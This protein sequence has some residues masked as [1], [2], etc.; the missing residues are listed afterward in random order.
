[1][2]GATVVLVHGAGAGA[3]A[4]DLVTAELDELGIAHREVDLPSCG[5]KPP[6]DAGVAGD[7]AVVRDL[8][9]ALTGPVV[10]VGNSYGGV[11]I[12]A[13]A[14]DHPAVARLVYI[15]AH[16]PKA[17]I[18]L[19]NQLEGTEESSA[20]LVLTEDGRAGFDPDQVATLAFQ[21]ADPETAKRVI[22][23]LQ[24]VLMSD[25]MD[26][27]L[28]AVAWEGIPSTYIVCTEDHLIPPAYQQRCATEQATEKI[29]VPYDHAPG[30]SHPAEVAQMLA[31]ITAEVESATAKPTP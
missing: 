12:S 5:S 15:A 26:M 3:W 24:P 18:P 13:A 17:G 14:V 7:T 19:V 21:Q 9:D 23:R 30:F 31:A 16:M 4:W 11:I 8:L 10:L 22:A 2:S 1:M 25:M 29:E 6:P 28:P 27:V 20:A